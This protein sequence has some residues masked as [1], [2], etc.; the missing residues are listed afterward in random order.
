MTMRMR[1]ATLTILLLLVTTHRVSAEDRRGA[2][3]RILEQQMDVLDGKAREHELTVRHIQDSCLGG[4]SVNTN[5]GGSGEVARALMPECQKLQGDAV[6]LDTEV[7]EG[8]EKARHDARRS[9]VYPGVVRK[10]LRSH[11]LEKFA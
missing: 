7:R 8:I 5:N 3:T 2:G 11:G 4:V 10:L 9:G 6:R 1:T